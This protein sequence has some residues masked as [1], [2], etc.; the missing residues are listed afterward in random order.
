[1]FAEKHNMGVFGMLAVLNRYKVI[2]ILLS[3]VLFILI[4]WLFIAGA[5]KNKKP[6][7]GVFVIEQRAEEY[8][9]KGEI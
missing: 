6:V 3:I 5:G 7:R 9:L 1:M 2:L 4:L 8:L